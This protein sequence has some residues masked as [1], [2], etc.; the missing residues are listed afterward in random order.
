MDLE[1]VVWGYIPILIALLVI[2]GSF[3]LTAK[4]RNLFGF[5]TTFLILGLNGLAIYILAQIITGAYPTYTP[6]L[7][8]LVSL[9]LLVVQKF[10][11]KKSKTF[12]NNV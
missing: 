4:R 1:I 12:A 2:G 7:F 10:V 9:I 3:Y 5:V 11:K 6:H 8:I